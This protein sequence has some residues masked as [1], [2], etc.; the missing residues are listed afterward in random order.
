VIA[1]VLIALATLILLGFLGVAIGGAT[2]EPE[3]S[4][5]AHRMGIA[6]GIWTLFS[7]V[8]ATGLGSL[9]AGRLSGVTRPL[10]GMLHGAVVFSLTLC[11][12]IGAVVQGIGAALSPLGDMAANASSKLPSASL[13]SIPTDQEEFLQWISAKTRGPE[14]DQTIQVLTSVGVERSRSEKILDEAGKSADRGEVTPELRS[15]A[16]AIVGQIRSAA[17]EA[18]RTAAKGSAWAFAS[19]FIALLACLATGA[20]G[21]IRTPRAERKPGG[22]EPARIVPGLQH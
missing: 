3:V 14:R 8:A 13:S 4:G 21:A 22:R 2:V 17:R 18:S 1:G 6:A 12:L 19:C 9:V 5:V 10:D 20:A 11:L 7:L 15:Q 16:G